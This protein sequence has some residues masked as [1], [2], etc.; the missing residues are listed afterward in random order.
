MYLT[1]NPCVLTYGANISRVLHREQGDHVSLVQTDGLYVTRSLIDCL[2]CNMCCDWLFAAES[3]MFPDMVFEY[4]ED[5][6]DR[7]DILFIIH[8]FFIGSVFDFVIQCL[9]HPV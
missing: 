8:E 4:N 3:S 7:G 9:T 5:E 1:N 2:L 6:D